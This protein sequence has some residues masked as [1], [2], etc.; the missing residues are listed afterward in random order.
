M[1]SIM[2]QKSSV[3]SSSSESLACGDDEVTVVLPN[4]YQT[5]LKQ[6]PVVNIHYET[7]GLESQQWMARYNAQDENACYRSW[8]IY[9]NTT[10]IITTAF[11]I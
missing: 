10:N 3:A 7:V 6:R 5:F 8:S 2:I 4:F 1:E 9:E 11:A